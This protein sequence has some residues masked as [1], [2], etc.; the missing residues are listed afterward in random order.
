MIRHLILLIA[1]AWQI[2]LAS[3]QLPES[4]KI[5][6]ALVR[7]G[8]N[9]G[10]IERALNEVPKDQQAGMRFL[11]ENMP[12]RDLTSLSAEFLLENSDLT[13]K[14][15]NGTAWAQEIPEDIV[16]DNLL[17]Y[18][19]INERRDRWRNDFHDRFRTLVADAKSPSKAAVI[20]NQSVFPMLNVKYSTGRKKADQSPF[21]SMESGLA[22]CTGLSVLLVDACRAVGVPA[23]IVGTPLWSDQSGNHTWVEIWDQG[24]HFTGACEP[25]GN[26][27]NQ[28]WFIDRA[29]TAQR[30]EP[31]HA[32]FAVTFR[33]NGQPMP[34][35]WAREVHD[36][37]AVNV[38]DRYTA[39][40]QAVPEGHALVRF[41]VL[42]S[43]AGS[44]LAAE[45]QVRD[46]QGQIVFEG[47]TRDDRF[48]LNDH[49]FTTLPKNTEYTAEAVVK[50]KRT[51]A[52][53]LA[54]DEELLIT[55]TKGL[56]QHGQSE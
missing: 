26:E 53:F 40:R 42:S 18:A 39:G 9:R 22:S 47:L 38:T 8:E 2:N 41:R 32:I 3:G 19:S 54:L 21:E 56:P 16:F 17:P 12:D 20:L 15:L 33:K 55:I 10:E 27:L 31:E 30:D 45:L 44:R 23:R 11:V 25:A 37:F 4:P 51:F 14:A 46:A 7:A 24:W 50:G 49:L 13:W 1:A 43:E 29:S 36:V 34:M 48:D 52:K 5:A 35:V 28:A 6:Q